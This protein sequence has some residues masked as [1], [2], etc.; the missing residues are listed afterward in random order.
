M[1]NITNCLLEMQVLCYQWSSGVYKLELLVPITAD[2][3]L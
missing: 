2:V 1:L 3:S